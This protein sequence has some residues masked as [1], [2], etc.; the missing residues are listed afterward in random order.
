MQDASV[1]YHA[2]SQSPVPSLTNG[3]SSSASS[4]VNSLS[5]DALGTTPR[6]LLP[7]FEAAG[8]NT[9][10][11]DYKKQAA[12]HC[13]D[14]STRKRRRESVAEL[15]DTHEQSRKRP[16]Q[17][18]S[19][20]E[21]ADA[22][23][24]D[25]KHTMHGESP[26]VTDRKMQEG[27]TE[28]T[29]TAE[30]PK[31][32]VEP[33]AAALHVRRRQPTGSTDFVSKYG[34]TDLYNQFVRPYVGEPRQALPGVA[35]AYLSDVAS[36]PLATSLDL[37]GLVMAPPKNDFARLDLLPMASIR[38]AFHMGESKRA[39][40]KYAES[41]RTRVSL[42]TS[43]G[44]TD[45]HKRQKGSPMAKREDEYERHRTAHRPQQ[46]SPHKAY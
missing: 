11:F 14:D 18:R 7:H 28:L 16:M 32:V 45:V 26:E 1:R 43:D 33:T 46:M 39:D 6:D 19:P 36:T 27:T 23:L 5:P 30:K 42:K 9:H 41:K 15:T 2:A 22:S 3:T 31:S 10:M 20:L 29:D 17:D 37:V 40:A 4:S 38:A 21:L 13:A 25:R 44:R 35:T 34:L 24:S 8:H 12:L